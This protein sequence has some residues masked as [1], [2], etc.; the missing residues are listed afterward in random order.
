[1]R[2]ANVFERKILRLFINPR[3]MIIAMGYLASLDM[4]IQAQKEGSGMARFARHPAP[5]SNNTYDVILSEAKYPLAV[6]DLLTLW[7]DSN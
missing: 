3:I 5:L 2:D 4:I 1:M 7:T 6:F